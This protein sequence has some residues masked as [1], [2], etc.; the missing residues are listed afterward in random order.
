MIKLRKLFPKWPNLLKMESGRSLT[1]VGFV[2]Q[3]LQK[4]AQHRQK[5]FG[6]FFENFDGITRITVNLKVFNE[7]YCPLAKNQQIRQKSPLWGFSNLFSQTYFI[8]TTLTS[9][10]KR[11][12][13]VYF[14]KLESFYFHFF[15][16]FS[17]LMIVLKMIHTIFNLCVYS[18]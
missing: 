15:F 8:F 10:I 6:P 14:K 3:F 7:N 5:I 4:I 1:L 18:F 2:S 11:N 13:N 16:C 9:L 12:V 17:F